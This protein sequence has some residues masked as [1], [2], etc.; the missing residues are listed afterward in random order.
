MTRLFRS[1]LLGSI[2]TAYMP[3]DADLVI[4]EDSKG[5]DVCLNGKSRAGCIAAG[6][7]PGNKG[8]M[9]QAILQRGLMRPVRPLSAVINLASSPCC[10]ADSTAVYKCALLQPNSM[11]SIVHALEQCQ[12][13]SC[14]FT[15]L[16]EP[17]M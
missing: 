3:E 16:D 14:L 15:M 5:V 9:P 1:T 4:G 10:R 6:H 11:K 2:Y 13:Q 17:C 8:A 7:H 12:L